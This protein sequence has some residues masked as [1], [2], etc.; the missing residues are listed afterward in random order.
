MEE[1]CQTGSLLGTVYTLDTVGTV[2]RRSTHQTHWFLEDRTFL[3]TTTNKVVGI[4][5]YR[6]CVFYNIPTFHLKKG[7][8]F[9]VNMS[10]GT[11]VE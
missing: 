1:N 11:I 3:S 7:R 6:W 9:N 10:Y 4:V 2:L 5:Y 8:V